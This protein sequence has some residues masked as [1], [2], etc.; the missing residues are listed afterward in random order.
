MTKRILVVSAG[1]TYP[2]VAIKRAI[3]LVRMPVAEVSGGPC[4][5]RV[6]FVAEQRQ[7]DIA[8]HQQ[9]REHFDPHD[10]QQARHAPG[11][12]ALDQRAE[13][14]SQMLARTNHDDSARFNFD[15]PPLSG[16]R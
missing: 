15:R 3:R 10:R 7:Q 16:P 11:G 4:L 5:T 13:E 14:I 1:P 6:V 9:Q 8:E 2:R 12:Q